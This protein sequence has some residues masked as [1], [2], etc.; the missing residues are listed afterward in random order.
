MKLARSRQLLLLAISIAAMIAAAAIT[1]YASRV[2]PDTHAVAV[3]PAGMSVP[4]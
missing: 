1:A 4:F 2:Q 3:Q